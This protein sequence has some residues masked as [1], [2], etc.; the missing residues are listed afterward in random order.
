[1]DNYKGVLSSILQRLQVL[2]TRKSPTA[3][4]KEDASPGISLTSI[5]PTRILAS[6]SAAV[7][8]TSLSASQ[9]IA[10]KATHI[11][12]TARLRTGVLVG[13]VTFKIDARKDVND[14][15]RNI[16]TYTGLVGTDV[17]T[18]SSCLIPIGGG[19]IFDYE[20]TTTGANPVSFDLTLEGFIA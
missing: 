12:C 15:T 7:A 6:G 18:S 8:W 19:G 9:Y 4:S 17:Q 2:E 3:K 10:E 11:Y 16:F 14:A 13:T 5:N 20:V 1:M